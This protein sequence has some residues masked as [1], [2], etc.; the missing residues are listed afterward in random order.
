MS[1]YLCD[2]EVFNTIATEIFEFIDKR[3]FN[4]EHPFWNTCKSCMAFA[5]IRPDGFTMGD[6]VSHWTQVE[7]LARRLYQMNVDAVK[8][9]YPET[10]AECWPNAGTDFEFKARGESNLIQLMKTIDCLL[11]QCNEGKIDE[12]DLFLELKEISI[13]LRIDYVNS[14][15]SYEK[16]N[17][18]A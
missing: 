18:G 4:N 14:L 8:T 1:A 12:S 11:Y 15:E 3:K 6:M 16:A 9:R 10:W 17:W 13:S 5:N 2:N 7:E